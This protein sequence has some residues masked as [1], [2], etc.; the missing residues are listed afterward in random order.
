MTRQPY[1]VNRG[2]HRF[3]AFTTACTFLLL[4][5]GA[6]VTSN[7]AGLAVPDW[8]L[9]YGSLTPP[10]IGGIFY[11]HGHRMIATLVGILTIIL[12]LWIWRADHRSWMRRLG[13]AALG[14]I[15]AQ[16]L[17]GGITVKFLL[18]PP[19]SMAHATLA[20]LFFITVFSIAIF[21]GDWWGSAQPELVD[22]GSPRL[23]LIAA[24]TTGSIILQTALGAGFRHGAFGIGPHLVGAA[25]VLG[26][27]IWVSRT[28]RIRFGEIASLRKAVA[29]LH[30]FLGVQIL[31]GFAAYWAV[32]S[33]AHAPQPLP[34]YITVTVAHVLG[35]ALTL[36]ASTLLLLRAYRITHFSSSLLPEQARA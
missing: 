33:A 21:T 35:G 27:A 1:A 36:A 16:G 26:M 24:L 11:E 5:A 12:A 10:M 14:L 15:V 6:L 19:I 2:L 9:S 28:V 4:M 23:T 32:M 22:G 29:L 13:W 25:L 17:L 3:A 20:Q 30:G 7:D 18:P 8:P 31:L 34:L